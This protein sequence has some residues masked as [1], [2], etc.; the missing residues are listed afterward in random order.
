M[1]KDYCKLKKTKYQVKELGLFFLYE[2]MQEC[3]ITEFIPQLPGAG[4][5]PFHILSFLRVQP[6][7]VVAVW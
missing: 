7:G 5:L 1:L 3:G 4:I 2:K 6:W